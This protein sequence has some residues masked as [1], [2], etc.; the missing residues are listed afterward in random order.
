MFFR[1]A[2]SFQHHHYP[3]VDGGMALKICEKRNLLSKFG[4]AQL[5]DN[6]RE[7]IQLVIAVAGNGLAV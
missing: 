7:E 1:R 2:S 6:K 5:I 3:A 4:S